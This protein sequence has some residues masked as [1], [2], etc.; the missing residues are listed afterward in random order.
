MWKN[1]RSL[2]FWFEHLLFLPLRF[3]FAVCSGNWPFVQ[4]FFWALSLKIRG[5]SDPHLSYGLV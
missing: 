1:F 4:G 5:K 2:S 3:C